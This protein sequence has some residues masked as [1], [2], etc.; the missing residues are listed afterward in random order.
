MPVTITDEVLQQTGMDEHEALIEVAC[1]LFDAGK[2]TQGQSARMAG[3]NREEFEHE[4]IARNIPLNRPTMEDFEQDVKTLQDL[5]V[6]RGHDR[7]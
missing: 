3:L 7:Q 2:L 4:A 1:R 5:G 6:M